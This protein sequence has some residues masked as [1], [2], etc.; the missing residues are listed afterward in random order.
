[1]IE[2]TKRLADGRLVCTTL[3]RDGPSAGSLQRHRATSRQIGC[4]NSAE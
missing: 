3:L 1:M 2:T 4:Q